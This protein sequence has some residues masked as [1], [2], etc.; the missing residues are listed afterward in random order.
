MVA[1][2]HV[3]S[4][5]F[6]LCCHVL[7]GKTSYPRT[8]IKCLNWFL[9]FVQTTDGQTQTQK[10]VYHFR[11]PIPNYSTLMTVFSEVEEDFWQQFQ[12]VEEQM[13]FP[14]RSRSSSSAFAHRIFKRHTVGVAYECCINKGCTMHELRSYCAP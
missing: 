6:V 14:F 7:L 1:E 5:F 13:K 9:Q 10:V 4:D 2:E 11:I 8:S 12:P 3:C